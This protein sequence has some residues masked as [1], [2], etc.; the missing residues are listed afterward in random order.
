MEV[1]ILIPS[2]GFIFT[3]TIQSVLDNMSEVRVPCTLIFENMKPIPEAQNSI[4]A[5]ALSTKADYFWFVEEDMIFPE[6]T[7]ST[8]VQA[9]IQTQCDGVIVDYPVGDHWSTICHKDG[10]VLWFGFGC[11]LMKR[12]VFER[13]PFPWFETSKSVKITDTKHMEYEIDKNTPFKY[14]GHDILFGLKCQDIKL[15][16]AE[17]R[18]IKA[19]QLRLIELGKI[20]YNNGVH[21]ITRLEGVTKNQE[22]FSKPESKEVKHGFASFSN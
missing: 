13:I 8:M 6:N 9:A 17:I 1:A 22:Y 4:V 12:S 19:G 3:D 18:E 15:K 16:L 7:L 5:K 14:G 11:T 10:K 20:G 2:R 21:T